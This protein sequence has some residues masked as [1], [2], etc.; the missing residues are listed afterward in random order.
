VKRLSS[1]TIFFPFYNDAGTVEKMITEAFEEGS[2]ST[3]DLEV[4]ALHGGASKDNTFDEI[5]KMKQK[6]PSLKIIDKSDNTE[7]YAVIKYGLKAATKDLVFYT[8]GDAQYSVKEDFHKLV[9]LQIKT[10]ADVVNGY[11]KVRGD[12]LI[13]TFLGNAYSLF[14]RA[15]FRSPIR[16]MD[17]DFRL[18][19]NNLLKKIELN[20]HDASILPE[21]VTKLKLM[22]AK[23][24]ETPVHHY[25]RSYGKSNYN[26]LQLTKEKLLGDIRLYVKFKKQLNSEY[27]TVLHYASKEMSKSKSPFVRAISKGDYRI[28][29]FLSVGVSSVLIQ[30]IIFNILIIGFRVHP[31]IATILSDQISIVSSFILNSRYT[32]ADKNIHF[33]LSAIFKRFSKYYPVVVTSTLIQAGIVFIGTSVFGSSILVANISLGIGILIGIAWNYTLQN[34]LVWKNRF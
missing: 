6:Y 28:L 30:S 26:P 2:K 25:E 16:D 12:N 27:E 31:V 22:K 13:R 32:F 14:S 19:K 3:N 4:I 18:I 1:F 11:K 7:G 29:K 33:A 21:L 17:C 34:L 10:G 20:S 23:F 24:A 8:D 5:K 9:E 15:L